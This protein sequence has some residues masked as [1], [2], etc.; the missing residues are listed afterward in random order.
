MRDMDNFNDLVT[1]TANGLAMGADPAD[2]A[3]DLVAKVGE[4]QAF[5]IF[6]AARAYL[7]LPE[8]PAPAGEDAEVAP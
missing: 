5:L 6:H 3:A 1:S 4:E 8:P 7:A 2:V